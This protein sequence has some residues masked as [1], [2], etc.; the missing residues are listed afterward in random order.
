MNVTTMCE[1]I[2]TFIVMILYGHESNADFRSG[3][4]WNYKDLDTLTTFDKQLCNSE[5]YDVLKENNCEQ[6]ITI[7]RSSI[8]IAVAMLLQ[9]KDA[10][11][12]KKQVPVKYIRNAMTTISINL[13]NAYSEIKVVKQ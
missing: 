2:I 8:N 3:K 10:Y 1:V 4:T 12:R 6:G 11:C 7:N 9:N 5:F 13:R